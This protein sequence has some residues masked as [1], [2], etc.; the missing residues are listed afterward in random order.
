MY[1]K[2]FI[3][4][5]K[6]KE[7]GALCCLALMSS[8]QKRTV[9]LTRLVLPSKACNPILEALGR[10]CPR[11]QELLIPNSELVTDTGILHLVPS[12]ARPRSVVTR[13]NK[14][15]SAHIGCPCLVTIDLSKC[16]NVR[17]AGAQYLLQGLKKLKRLIYSNMKALLENFLKGKYSGVT[18]EKIEYFESTEFSS[19]CVHSGPTK[20]MSVVSRMSFIP[21]IFPNVTTLKLKLSDSEVKHLVEVPKLALLELEITNDPGKGLQHLLD[22][23]PNI[24]NWLHICLEVGPIAA[25]HLITI[26]ENCRKLSFLK[27]KGYRVENCYQLK[28]SG[29]YFR[30]LSNLSLKFHNL[31]DGS[32]DQYGQQSNRHSPEMIDFFLGSGVSNLETVDIHMNVSHFLNDLYL[33][34]LVTR[35]NI[36][37]L[38]SLSL[39]G[40]DILPLSSDSVDWILNKLDKIHTLSISKWQISFCCLWGIRQHARQHN[41]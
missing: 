2:I 37:N 13:S 22:H 34:D 25:E 10:C 1:S 31:C 39:T 20:W 5:K 16:C 19:C 8:L 41:F 40:P 36:D 24:A 14:Q 35:S 23:H 27:I 26:A 33:Q 21:I 12:M 9:T 32:H 30:H 3:L 28:P 17:P 6:I 15:M 11:L 4:N 18:F 29:K 7:N 38:R